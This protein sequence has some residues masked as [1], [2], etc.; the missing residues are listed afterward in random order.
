MWGQWCH[1]APRCLANRLPQDGSHHLSCTLHSHSLHCCQCC[2]TSRCT[3]TH[4]LV[5]QVDVWCGLQWRGVAQHCLVVVWC[6][7]VYCGTVLVPDG[8]SVELEERQPAAKNA[9]IH[10]FGVSP[11]SG[12][13]EV[14][15]SVGQPVSKSQVAMH[16]GS[17]SFVPV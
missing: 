5:E 7:A 15:Q 3:R 16:S 14:L 4:R 17:P 6:R 10:D 9:S 2:Y 13:V 1:L 11:S 12:H 8:D